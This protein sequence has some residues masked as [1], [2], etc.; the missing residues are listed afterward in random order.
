[1]SQNEKV[2][3][4]LTARSLITGLFLC[5]VLSI[6]VQCVTFLAV[7]PSTPGYD[8]SWRLLDY[9]P[10]GA[11]HIHGA[12]CVLALILSITA[13]MRII[14]EKYRFNKAEL[15]FLITSIMTVPILA[16]RDGYSMLLTAF[17]WDISIG[18]NYVEHTLKNISPNFLVNDEEL[19]RQQ[20][21]GGVPVPWNAWIVPLTFQMLLWICLRLFFF[22]GISLIQHVYIDQEALAFPMETNV[23]KTLIDFSSGEKKIGPLSSKES[24][25][26]VLISLIIGVL[27]FLLLKPKYWYPS[28]TLLE[29]NPLI[30]DLTPTGLL[31]APLK[32]NF[33]FADWGWLILMPI[34][35]LVTMPIAWIIFYVIIPP[36]MISTGNL[37]E[38]PPGT[39]GR[40]AVIRIASMRENTLWKGGYGPLQFGLILGLALVPLIRNRRSII[41]SI[42]SVSTGGPYETP[43]SPKV[44]W[45][46]WAITG[47]ATV[48]LFSMFEIPVWYSFV[49]VF[50]L[51]CWYMGLGRAF[52]KASAYM[53]NMDGHGVGWC[54][55]WWTAQLNHTVGLVGDTPAA[56]NS[57]WIVQQLAL[58]MVGN[59]GGLEPTN[60]A[61]W[62]LS[63]FKLGQLT[64]ADRKQMSVAILIGSLI[65]V[66][67]AVPLG[68][69]LS[70]TFG[71]Y[72]PGSG[73][74]RL[75]W[76]S[77]ATIS[78]FFSNMRGRPSGPWLRTPDLGSNIV[79][80]VGFVIVAVMEYLRRF[81]GAFLYMSPVGVAF[82]FFSSEGS[83]IMGAIIIS[84]V[85][86]IVFR[87]GGTKLYDEKIL[88][89]GVGLILGQAVSWIIK[90]ILILL[91]SAGFVWW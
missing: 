55:Q 85:R 42:K 51:S 22:F 47:L 65:P 25:R 77:R 12:F 46:G 50:F 56:F 66:L 89:I 20:F 62:H 26:I 63:G 41:R 21:Y 70:Y 69:W 84:I 44:L 76:P 79:T 48:G 58:P 33:N 86:L 53:M 5:I 32:L 8:E 16:D 6:I 57:Q 45:L 40:T 74:G 3:K 30:I 29:D 71:W 28:V 59:N 60:P 35:V 82:A 43:L 4:A 18:A 24:K 38:I 68:L 90:T 80:I 2:E 36:I 34:D 87:V 78:T 19:L 31:P 52:A 73:L 88:P 14:P 49:L 23:T 64:K 10:K 9:E 72:A 75:C 91:Q 13:I 83:Y 67:I 11:A 27:W 1:V 61:I 37:T 54:G 39:S 81:G 15:A 7:N 17:S